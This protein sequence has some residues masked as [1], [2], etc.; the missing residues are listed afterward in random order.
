MQKTVYNIRSLFV[1]LLQKCIEVIPISVLLKILDKQM[2]RYNTKETLCVCSMA[3]GYS[4][5]KQTFYRTVYSNAKQYQFGE[6]LFFGVN[7]YKS[8]LK[9]L[10]GEEYMNIPAPEDRGITHEIY[11]KIAKD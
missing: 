3:S 11:R 7:D 6:N 2:R 9:Q 5:E 10:F 1:V 4:Y 8:Y